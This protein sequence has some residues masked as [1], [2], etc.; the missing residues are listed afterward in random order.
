MHIMPT[1]YPRA[2]NLFNIVK[3]VIIALEEISFRLI[4]LIADNN[5]INK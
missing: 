1:K 4:S 5:E 3:Y 2:E